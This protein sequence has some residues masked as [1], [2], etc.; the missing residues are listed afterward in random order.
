VKRSI[1]K[2]SRL[3]FPLDRLMASKS[4]PQPFSPHIYIYIYTHTHKQT[5]TP[6]PS[7]I[8]IHTDQ[9]HLLGKVQIWG[10]AISTKETNKQSWPN[11]KHD[12]HTQKQKKSF[13]YPIIQRPWNMGGGREY[14]TGFWPHMSFPNHHHKVGVVLSSSRW[15]PKKESK[16]VCVHQQQGAAPHQMATIR[17]LLL[18]NHGCMEC[19]QSV[20]KSSMIYRPFL[21]LKSCDNKY[22]LTN[23]PLIYKS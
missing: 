19:P 22:T 3:F 14:P 4:W 15:A 7:Y 2:W 16:C 1:L 11:F 5:R 10:G 21:C 23:S 12:S 13:Y 18:C 6:S 20:Q 9:Q 8:Y 17:A